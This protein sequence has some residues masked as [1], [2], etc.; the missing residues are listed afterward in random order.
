[1]DC[2]RHPDFRRCP[3]IAAGNTR[4]YAFEAPHRTSLGFFT[5]LMFST[6]GSHADEGSQ[7]DLERL[8][9]RIHEL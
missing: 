5:G 7:R 1:V 3:S 2:V 4:K 8:E 6:D 9:P